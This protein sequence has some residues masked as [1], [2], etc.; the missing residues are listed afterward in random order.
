MAKSNYKHKNSKENKIELFDDYG[1]CYM[2]HDQLFYFDIDD[3][4]LVKNH[5]WSMTATGYAA[6]Y[7]FTR[8]DNNK[9]KHHIM[10]FHR[11]VMNAPSN[12]DV[13]HIN[14]DKLDNRKHNLRVCQS[15]QNDYNKSISKRNKSGVIGVSYNNQNNTWRAYIT[16]KGEWIN[17]GSYSDKT[18]AIVARLQAERDYFCEFAPQQDLFDLYNIEH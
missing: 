6:S 13:D 9:R 4:Q 15:I 16:Y 11:Q 7:Y 1:I 18:D 12:M 8:D 14:R 5:Y 10:L 2:L 17:L 3:F